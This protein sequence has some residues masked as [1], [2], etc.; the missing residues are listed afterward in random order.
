MI[1]SIQRKFSKVVDLYKQSVGGEKKSALDKMERM[2]LKYGIDKEL[3]L[4]EIK[5]HIIKFSSVDDKHLFISILLHN[6]KSSS[7]V[8][9]SFGI[10]N[11]NKYPCY[12]SIHTSECDFINLK[13]QFDFYKRQFLKER[14]KILKN[15]FSAFILKNQLFP[16]EQESEEKTKSSELNFEEKQS[17]FAMADT[18]DNIKFKKEIES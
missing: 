11:A 5:E 18:M 7:P 8:C 10:Y 15:L 3:F 2:C 16:I 6:Y 1:T 12:G 13:N 4:N 14:R 9:E 17:I